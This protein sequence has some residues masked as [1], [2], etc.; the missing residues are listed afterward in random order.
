MIVYEDDDIVVVDKPRGVAAH[1]TPGW[2]GPTVLGGLLGAGHASIGVWE[3][4]DQEGLVTVLIPDWERVRN[5]PQRNPLHTFTVDRH[6]M[7]TAAYAAALT[8]DVARPDLLL[9]AALLHDLGKGWPGDHSVS[10][11]VVARDVAHRVGFSEADAELVAQAA[12]H[13]LLLPMV[14]TRRDLDDPVT[15]EQVARTVGG[16][17]LLE[18]LQALAAADGMATGPAAWND[19]KAGL[20]SDLVKRVATVLAGDPPPGAAPLRDDQL[21]LAAK[22]GPAAIIKGNEVTVMAP[23]RPGLLWRAA[24][25]LASHR[26]TVRG[27]N[28]TSVGPTAVAVFN[29]V[30]EYGDPP[31]NTLVASDLHRMLEGRLDVEERLERRA[32]AARPRGAV[33]APPKVTMV[34]DASLTATVVEVRAHDE[35]GLLWRVGRALGGC[36]LDV[37]SARVETL[38]AEAVDVFYVADESGRPLTDK[39][40][41]QATVKAVLA[42]LT[43]LCCAGPRGRPDSLDVRTSGMREDG[44]GT[45]SKLF[46]NG[47]HKS[48]PPCGARGG[49]RL[50]TSTRLRARYVSRCW[51]PTSRS[52]SSGRS[53]PGSRSGRAARRSPAR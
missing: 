19:W 43:S 9:M 50:P 36:G 6:L 22:G 28:A 13:H 7:E 51:K 45:C 52:R 4:L 41:R 34:D 39:T 17:P 3:A 14:A 15:V 11:E 8:R 44:I 1:P 53:S 25:V 21:A 26:L 30:S 31:D 18:L 37:R 46:P 38:G 24:G 5:R 42:A 20:V 33:V 27:A 49:C 48:S 23:D 12:R 47:S 2:T 32:R 40:L 10:G 29:V 35:P 16:R